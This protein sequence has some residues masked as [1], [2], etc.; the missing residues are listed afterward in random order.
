MWPKWLNI[1]L[2]TKWLWARF[3]SS[4]INSRYFRIWRSS[5]TSRQLQSIASLKWNVCNMIKHTVLQDFN[6]MVCFCF[7]KSLV[8]EIQVTIVCL[9]FPWEGNKHV[10]LN[11]YQHLPS[12]MYHSRVFS[13]VNIF[14]YESD[15]YWCE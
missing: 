5:L 6:N 4:H 14:T 15:T 11:L 9:S 1:P 13:S 12:G 2:P 10:G 3:H 8:E 7:S